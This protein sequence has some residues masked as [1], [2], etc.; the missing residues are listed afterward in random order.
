MSNEIKPVCVLQGPIASRSGYG[1]HCF[2]IATAL[3]NSGKFDVKIIP[4]RWGVCPNTMLDDENAY[5]KFHLFLYLL[6]QIDKS[7]HDLLKINYGA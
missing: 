7:V 4:M 1:D 5:I 3:I 6:T 2:Q